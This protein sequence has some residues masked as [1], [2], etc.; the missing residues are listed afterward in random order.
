MKV[1]IPSMGE[2][3]LDEQVGQ[4]FGRVTHYTIVDLDTDDVNVI[5]NTSHHMGGTVEPPELLKKEGVCA[6]L[7][8]GL[9]RRAINLFEQMGIDVYVGASGK[10]RDAVTAYKQGNLQQATMA[11]GCQEHTFGGHHHNH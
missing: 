5:P 2:K 9:G 6:M 1:G 4:H 10:V 7:C 3:G 8:S 11:D